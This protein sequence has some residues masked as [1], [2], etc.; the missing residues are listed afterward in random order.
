[1]PTEQDR[2]ARRERIAAEIRQYDEGLINSRRQGGG[3]VAGYLSGA[4]REEIVKRGEA[5]AH[6]EDLVA[7]MLVEVQEIGSR[8][9]KAIANL[10]LLVNEVQR[11]SSSVGELYEMQ[12]RLMVELAHRA[13]QDSIHEDEITGV[14]TAIVK[15]DAKADTALT[16]AVKAQA[17][18]VGLKAAGWAF[19]VALFEALRWLMAATGKGLRT[20]TSR[21]F[22]TDWTTRRRWRCSSAQASVCC[23]RTSTRTPSRRMATR[24]WRVPSGWGET[25]AGWR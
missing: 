20:W 24:G 1:M 4:I 14:K 12:G 5:V 23:A 17:K 8:Q 6:V 18:Q 2:A 21:R 19:G 25:S 13:K 15:A 22:W 9:T 11:L 16:A 3:A 7:G 10:D